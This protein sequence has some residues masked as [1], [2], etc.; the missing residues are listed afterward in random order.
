MT[1]EDT[2]STRRYSQGAETGDLSVRDVQRF[3]IHPSEFGKLKAGE[4][5][6]IAPSLDI[7]EKVQIFQ[8]G[9]I[10]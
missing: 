9:A 2:K 3:R 8:D 5:Y 10:L 4:C 6:V 1:I 7:F